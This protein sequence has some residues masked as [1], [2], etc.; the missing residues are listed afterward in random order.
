MRHR[1]GNKK[2]LYTRLAGLNFCAAKFHFGQ[3]PQEIVI[4]PKTRSSLSGTNQAGH[5][6]PSGQLWAAGP[7]ALE[8]QK[9]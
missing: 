2:I 9:T 8:I 7:A 1:H 5:D 4:P 3:R 6:A